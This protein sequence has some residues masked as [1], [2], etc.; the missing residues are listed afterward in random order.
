M[1]VLELASSADQRLTQL[2]RTVEL[3][4]AVADID[5]ILDEGT[6]SIIAGFAARM[7]ESQI[8][9]RI[10]VSVPALRLRLEGASEIATGVHGVRE[11][12]LIL[13]IDGRRVSWV[14]A[15]AFG[16]LE[17]GGPRCLGICYPNRFDYNLWEGNDLNADKAR[18][19]LI[20][21]K[22]N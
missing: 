9:N 18:L 2:R 14:V 8:A 22:G 6:T 20:R 5:A 10:G 1:N 15:R 21:A 19:R 16:P 7:T 13:E 17:S 3:A 11:G 12:D 4:T